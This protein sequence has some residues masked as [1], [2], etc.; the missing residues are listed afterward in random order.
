MQF[1]RKIT[2]CFLMFAALLLSAC[3]AGGQ[4]GNASEYTVRYYDGSTLL[5]EDVVAA[6]ETPEAFVPELEGK[7]FLG[8]QNE[9]GEPADPAGEAA[10]RDVSYIALAFPILRAHTPYLFA[11]ENGFVRPDDALSADEFSL[12]LS[13]LTGETETGLPGGEKPVRSE[14][15]KTALL[16]YF[17]AE[18][19]AAFPEEG[20]ISRTAFA[21]LM[22]ALIGQGG[23]ERVIPAEGASAPVD[24]APQH[25]AFADVLEA[26]VPH[27][28]G[29]E[30][31]W[32]EAAPETG[33]APGALFL[34]GSLYCCGEDGRIL[35]GAE[36]EG[37]AFGEDGRYS[38]GDEELD[39][40]VRE[41]LAAL[42]DEYPEDAADRMAMLRHV[43]DYAIRNFHYVGRSTH[44]DEEGWEL[45]DGKVMLETG[46]GDCYNY[47]AGFTVLARGLG[48]PAT[49]ILRSL[50]GNDLHA[51]TDIVIDG[52]PYIFDPQLEKHFKNDRFMLT[53]KQ[54]EGYGYRRPFDTPGEVR[55]AF[56]DLTWVEPT[57]HGELVEAREGRFSYLVYLPYGYDESKQYNVLIYL[58]GADG[59]PY[60]ILGTAKGY[61]HQNRY[62]GRYITTPDFVSLFRKSYENLTLKPKTAILA[63]QR[64]QGGIL[65]CIPSG[66]KR[67]TAPVRCRNTRAHSW[68]GAAG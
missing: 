53:Y 1:L 32:R 29:G 44:S 50:D 36:A 15:I 39:A 62:F 14:E 25:A 34:H 20:T 38:C 49:P 65:L 18:E 23:E 47:T 7:R 33:H 26:S 10:G 30:R 12:A 43:Y 37:L 13:V 45:R 24:L 5:R 57:R 6:G 66:A 9:A 16:G 60:K 52:T 3:G 68:R 51:W 46:K 42:C 4:Q 17:T 28:P 63:E 2:V 59:D 55:E 22:N 54:G 67:S 31:G 61:A 27:E 64:S 40:Y 8:W 21:Q 35:R 19:L 41:I 58:Y 56:Q 48:F 11:D